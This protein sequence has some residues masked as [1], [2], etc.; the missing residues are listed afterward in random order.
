MQKR[1]SFAVLAAAVGALAGTLVLTAGAAATVPTKESFEFSDSR[2]FPAGTICDFNYHE[3]VTGSGWDEIFFDEAGN[4][5]RDTLHITIAVT[6]VNSDTGYV[7]TE[8]DT[9]SQTF[10]D[11]TQTLKVV[12]V[13]WLLKDSTGR[14]VVAHAGQLIF[15]ESVDDVTKVTPNFG[16]DFA[17]ELCP[18]LGGNP[19]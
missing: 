8:V 18:A 14:V 4:Y 3:E 11:A 16:G 7:L 12:G 1:K 6:H 19:A 5:V 15:D 13:E 9:G 10:V 2:D 17:E